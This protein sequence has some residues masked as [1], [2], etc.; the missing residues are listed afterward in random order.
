MESEGEERKKYERNAVFVLKCLLEREGSGRRQR[1]KSTDSIER[2][3]RK[4]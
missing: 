1:E 3:D 2:E 4:Q